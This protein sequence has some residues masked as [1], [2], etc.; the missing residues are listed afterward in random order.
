MTANDNPIV[1]DSNDWI[2]M[3]GSDPWRDLYLPSGTTLKSPS[4]AG[5]TFSVQSKAILTMH[6]DGRVT[7]GEGFTPDEAGKAAL[8]AFVE[9][10]PA[11]LQPY[12]DLL[13]EA[14]RSTHDT[15][16]HMH[17]RIMAFLEGKQ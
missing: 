14:A 9:A 1:P 3:T 6:E 8:D 5:I 15:D 16:L 17:M 10:W 13:L 2:P 11:L 7:I 12:K 4:P